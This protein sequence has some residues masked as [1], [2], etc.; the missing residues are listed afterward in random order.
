M[1]PWRNRPT[2]LLTAL[3]ALFA[4][5]PAQAGPYV[6]LD[7]SNGRVLAGKDVHQ[8]WYP[9][10]LTKLM[11]AY[12]A[13]R[14]VDTGTFQLNSPVV[15]SQK[16][17]REPPSKMGYPAGSVLA[18]DDALKIILVRS[19]NDVAT[20]IA[21]SIGG[22]EDAFAALM[23]AEAR[24]LGM[25]GSHF[26]NAHGLHSP[27]QYTTARDLALLV[28]AIRAEF[29][30]YAGYFSIEGLRHGKSVLRN[31][32]HLVGRF[33]GADGM[34]T[35]Y[36]CASGFNL[37][38]TATRGRRTLAA[39]VLGARSQVERTELAAELLAQGFKSSG[40]STPR[41]AS[42]RP[43]PSATQAAIDMRSEI[44]SAEA[45]AARAK[46][47]DNDGRFILN[48][49][50]VREMTREPRLAAV[51]LVTTAPVAARA[52]GA[53]RVPIP[54][55]RPEYRGTAAQPGR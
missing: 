35:G 41:L 6:L 2:I 26:V 31:T 15:I 48:S 7:V 18:L 52:S 14:A 37:V 30:Q 28:R 1:R 43:S 17:A 21:E 46:L 24:R 22:S 27:S 44:C 3:L 13:F 42:L 49:P 11:T 55:P 10:S 8:R 4:V 53:A 40:F 20:A 54:T 12:V 23:N 34:K 32:N 25:S 29:P 45:V 19:A 9:A 50:H 36:I 51:G 5:I 38:A 39:I 33:D 16:A 47:R